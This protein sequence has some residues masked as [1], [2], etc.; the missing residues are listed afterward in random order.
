MNKRDN[1]KVFPDHLK[2]FFTSYKSFQENKLFGNG[3]KSFRYKCKDFLN[4]KNT[5]CSTHPHNYHLEILHDSGLIGIFFIS[6]FT[7]GLL[8][9]TTKQ[10]ISK[11]LTFNQKIIISLIIFNFL[12]EI[13]PFKTSGSFFTTWNGTIL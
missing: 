1:K 5:L 6:L 12:I 11:E 7:F 2:L 8:L 9:K 3:L 13:F 4:I 10:L